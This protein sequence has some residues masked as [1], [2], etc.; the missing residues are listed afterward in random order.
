MIFEIFLAY[1]C[2]VHV[3]TFI[4]NWRHNHP[5][6]P[7][8][9][10]TQTNYRKKLFPK[11]IYW[12]LV[13]INELHR[14][15]NRQLLYY[16]FLADWKGLAQSGLDMFSKLGTLSSRTSFHRFKSQLLL[17]AYTISANLIEHDNV[18]FWMD[19]YTHVKMRRRLQANQ[20][21][22]ADNQWTGIAVI[23]P[24]GGQTIDMSVNLNRHGAIKAAVPR[25]LK[26]YIR[27]IGSL[28]DVMK[29]FRKPLCWE[30]STIIWKEL[31]SIPLRLDRRVPHNENLDRVVPLGI[32]DINS[33][34]KDG[35]VKLWDHVSSAVRVHARYVI[36]TVDVA[37]YLP[38]LRVCF[39]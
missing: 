9:S 21:L 23:K 18:V 28:H 20:S 26:V 31:K 22:F 16:T 39:V 12:V 30:N 34:S 10:A 7:I 35:L 15:S 32:Y 1:F 13:S 29:Q 5:R 3:A 25:S 38:S 8:P 11:C 6:T 17:D 27:S 14:G 37:L 4:R 36:V 24:V 33:S 19:N 2:A